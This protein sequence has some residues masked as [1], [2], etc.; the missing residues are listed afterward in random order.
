MYEVKC[1]TAFRCPSPTPLENVSLLEQLDTLPFI[2]DIVLDITTLVVIPI[3]NYPRAHALVIDGTHGTFLTNQHV[4][5]MMTH[6]IDL[7]GPLILWLRYIEQAALELLG[8]ETAFR[9]SPSVTVLNGEY[10]FALSSAKH[11]DAIWVSG[12]LLQE[13]QYTAKKRLI[14]TL[15]Q[16]HP[17][18]IQ[19]PTTMP[20]RQLT[21]LFQFA[22]VVALSYQDAI[23]EM[24]SRLKPVVLLEDL[25]RVAT[26]TWQLT[27][28][29]VRRVI[30]QLAM[31]NP[32][33]THYG[34]ADDFVDMMRQKSFA[35]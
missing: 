21:N 16:A 20:L 10:Y 12:H 23:S 3:T 32:D 2:P 28:D 34:M 35:Q 25:P 7:Q 30:D 27:R 18:S 14:I 24:L 9:S 19:L 6:L 13:W 1:H 33:W 26:S 29:S 17:L 5:S 4:H 8:F 15:D 31:L 22:T 11:R